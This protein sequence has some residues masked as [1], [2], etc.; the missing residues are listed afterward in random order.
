MK[1]GSSS[2]SVLLQTQHVLWSAGIGEGIAYRPVSILKACALTL[3]LH[4]GILR[5]AGKVR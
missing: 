1:C 4:I 5:Y 2:I 3:N